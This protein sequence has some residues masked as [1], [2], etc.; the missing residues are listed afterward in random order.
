[1]AVRV[2]AQVI[3][4]GICGEQSGAEA[5]FLRVLRFPLPIFIPSIAPHSPS[6]IIRGWYNRPNSNWHTKWTQSH[7]T[8]RNRKKHTGVTT[9]CSAVRFSTHSCFHCF[10]AMTGAIVVHCTP[11]MC[12]LQPYLHLNLPRSVDRHPCRVQITNVKVDNGP[13]RCIWI[14]GSLAHLF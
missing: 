5:G 10:I 11:R 8:Q 1:M 4:R 2:Q 9:W 6:S 14:D 13:F 7:P 3:S 12:V